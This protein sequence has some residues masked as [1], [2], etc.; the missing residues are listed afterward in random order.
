MEHRHPAR[1]VEVDRMGVSERY[2]RCPA[3]EAKTRH[4]VL[5]VKKDDEIIKCSKCGALQY[6]K[7]DGDEKEVMLL[8][9]KAGK[10]L[11]KFKK[12]ESKKK[13]KKGDVIGFSKKDYEIRSIEDESGQRVEECSVKDARTIW[14]VPFEK[15]LSISIYDEGKDTASKKVTFAKDAEVE[16]G[17]KLKAGRKEVKITAILTRGGEKKKERVEDILA[18]QGRPV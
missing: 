7:G 3:C 1:A 14:L 18:L 12:F 5:R 16:V 15:T 4:K 11:K 2:A 13:F 8:L 10:A 6:A 17:Q 9:S